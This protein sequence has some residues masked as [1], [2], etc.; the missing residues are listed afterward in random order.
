MCKCTFI[1]YFQI[2]DKKDIV[3]IFGSKVILPRGQNPIF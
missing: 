1:Q 3:G 2:L